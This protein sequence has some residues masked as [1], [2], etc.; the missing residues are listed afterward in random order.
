MAKLDLKRELPHLYKAKAGRIDV[1]EVPALSYLMV[2]GQGAPGGDAYQA[3]LEVLYPVAYSLKFR[4][5]QADTPRDFVV[6]PLQGQWWAD[7]MNDFLTREK[8]T[9]KWNLM[10]LQPD[11]MTKEDFDA[12]V[13]A[14]RTKKDPAALDTLRFDSFTEGTCAQTLHVGPFDDEGPTIEALHAFIGERGDLSGKHHEVY[15]SDIRRAAPA[16]WKTI[17]RQPF[18]PEP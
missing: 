4:S 3:A 5:K 6:A 8:S 15:L 17:L 11:W 1:V 2:E 10:I 16:N 12:V 9:W 14:V 13:D 7:D 18:L